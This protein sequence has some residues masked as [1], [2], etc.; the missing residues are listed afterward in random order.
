MFS[1]ALAGKLLRLDGE[2]HHAHL[3]MSAT[4]LMVAAAHL[5]MSATG[6][7]VAV[8]VFSAD[9]ELPDTEYPVSTWP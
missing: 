2:E 3:V 4:G 9:Q 1:K 6:F 8:R 5:V 7:I